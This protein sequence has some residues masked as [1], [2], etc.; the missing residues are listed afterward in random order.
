MKM[1]DDFLKANKI[2][3]KK[4]IVK[5]DPILFAVKVLDLFAIKIVVL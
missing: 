1:K 2:F 4:H 3:I 5:S